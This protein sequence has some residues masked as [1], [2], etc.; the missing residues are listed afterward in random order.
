MPVPKKTQPIQ[1]GRQ[2]LNKLGR[3]AEA[4][5]I[6]NAALPLADLQEL[7]AYARSLPQQKKAREELEVFKINF[8]KNPNDLQH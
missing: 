1:T 2:I 8:Q 5:A 3:T 4:V 6:M 7:H